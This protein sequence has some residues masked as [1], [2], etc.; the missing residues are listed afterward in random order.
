MLI[1][2]NEMLVSERHTHTH[3]HV[4]PSGVNDT[5]TLE[6]GSMIRLNKGMFSET[7]IYKSTFQYLFDSKLSSY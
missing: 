1:V 3:T 5:L 4:D 6:E 7:I 2:E